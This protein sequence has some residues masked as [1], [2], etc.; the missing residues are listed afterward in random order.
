[1]T[2]ACSF[3]QQSAPWFSPRQGNTV[4]PVKVVELEGHSCSA[5]SLQPMTKSAVSGF[6]PRISS[7]WLRAVSVLIRSQRRC[8]CQKL[9]CH[10]QKISGQKAGLHWGKADDYRVG[11]FLARSKG[12]AVGVVAQGVDAQ[13]GNGAMRRTCRPFRQWM[14]REL[15]GHLNSFI[16]WCGAPMMAAAGAGRK[17]GPCGWGL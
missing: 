6:T 1:M 7:F 11:R 3:G 5:A 10:G 2:L 12:A 8:L 14:G 16:G 13:Q 9:G 17:S 15:F 4:S